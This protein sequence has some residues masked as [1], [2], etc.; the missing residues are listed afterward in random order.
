LSKPK[1]YF[2]I[3]LRASRADLASEAKFRRIE[4]SDMT[5]ERS[6]SHLSEAKLFIIYVL[7]TKP[8][9]PYSFLKITNQ[10]HHF[11][12]KAL[13]IAKPFFK[14]FTAWNPLFLRTYN[15]CTTKLM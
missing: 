3:L 5:G 6:E 12:K 15:N 10:F 4:R 13:Q 8:F 9:N 2:Q 11:T 7:F 1:N 14:I